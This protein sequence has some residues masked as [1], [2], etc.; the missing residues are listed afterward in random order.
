MV[1]IFKVDIISV[2]GKNDLHSRNLAADGT[3][4]TTTF[5][6]NKLFVENRSFVQHETTY[7]QMQKL[8]HGDNTDDFATTFRHSEDKCFRDIGLIIDA[9]S[10]DLTYGGI[11]KTVDAA[12]SYWNGVTSRVAGQQNETVAPINF[13]KGLILQI[14]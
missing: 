8:P 14:F 1:L 6:A 10:F 13:A 5:L 12:A 2:R 3:E 4:D 11:S 9:V 7:P